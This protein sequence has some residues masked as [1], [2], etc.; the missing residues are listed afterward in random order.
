MCINSDHYV[1]DGTF[2][3]TI[4]V[5]YDVES[6]KFKMAVLARSLHNLL[7]GDLVITRLRS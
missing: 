1:L 4:G 2:P 5:E 3:E 7:P 6:G